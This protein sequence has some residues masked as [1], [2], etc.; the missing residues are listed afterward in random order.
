MPSSPTVPPAL[1][2]VPFDEAA[3]ASAIDACQRA[4]GA[5]DQALATRAAAAA[6]ARAEWRGPF[7]DRFDEELAV[8]DRRAIVLAA[9]LR[10]AAA[11]ISEA[12]ETARV[13]NASRREARILW[14]RSQ[15]AG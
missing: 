15:L 1:R 14:E 13:Q 2:P 8:L 4:A 5:V 9:D 7:R 10:R 3:A 12:R 6:T 11:T